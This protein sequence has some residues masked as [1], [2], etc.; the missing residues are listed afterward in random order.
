MLLSVPVWLGVDM[1]SPMRVTVLGSAGSFPA[2]GR[3]GSGFLVAEGTT[4]LLID[5]GPG[6]FFALAELMDPGA[7]DGIVI[8]HTHADHCSDF[9]AYFHYLAYGPGGTSPMPVFLPQGA[10]E[11]LAGLV[12]GDPAHT[13]FEVFDLR[14][15]GDDEISLGA[16]ALRFAPTD[17]S[18]PTVAVRVEVGGTSLVYSSDTG[19]EGGVPALAGFADVLLCEATLQGDR[20]SEGFQQHLTAA[21]AGRIASAA[22]VGRLVL[23]HLPPS[24]DAAVSIAEASAVFARPV[25]FAEPGTELE[26]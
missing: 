22:G 4:N 24:L 3:P 25:T 8:T 7:L 18:V 21:E 1:L 10:P 20:P 2:A 17:H 9:Y 16:L 23:T 13:F 11:L 5:A 6:T 15:V 19:V 12:G 14:V 26:V